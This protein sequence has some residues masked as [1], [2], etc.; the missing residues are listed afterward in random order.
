MSRNKRLFTGN[1]IKEKVLKLGS[2]A[3][4]GEYYLVSTIRTFTFAC[5]K[6]IHFR[7]SKRFF[8]F[9]FFPTLHNN[10]TTHPISKFSFYNTIY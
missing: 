10:F 1:K 4:G 6:F 7:S 5:L 9:F 8:F 2:F 3:M